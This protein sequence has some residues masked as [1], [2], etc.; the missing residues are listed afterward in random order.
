MSVLASHSLLALTNGAAALLASSTSGHAVAQL[1]AQWPELVRKIEG[2]HRDIFVCAQLRMLAPCKQLKH[3]GDVL[4]LGHKLGLK[5][6]LRTAKKIYRILV[7]EINCHSSS[8]ECYSNH[9][10]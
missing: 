7:R 5:S 1:T 2:V 3:L 10:K 4:A 9:I 6:E 8:R